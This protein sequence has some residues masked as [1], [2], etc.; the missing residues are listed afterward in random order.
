MIFIIKTIFM[1]K[2]KNSNLSFTINVK[3]FNSNNDAIDYLIEAV[4]TS[5]EL[6]RDSKFLND[7]KEA[8]DI[9]LSLKKNLKIKIKDCGCN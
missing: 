1:K 3:D 7:M 9:T 2:L 5:L 6:N 8:S 4:Q